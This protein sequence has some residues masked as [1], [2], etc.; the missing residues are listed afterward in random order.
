MKYC[1]TCVM[2]DTRPGIVFDEEGVCSPCRNYENRANVDW[3][4]RWQE[5]LEL[6]DTY[7]GCN[8]D[9]YDCLI[10][11]SGGKDSHYQTYVFKEVLG[12]NPLL[13]SVD[14]FSWTETG[15]LNWANLRTRF[16]V[17]NAASV[18]REGELGAAGDSR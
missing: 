10:A 1:K 14:N 13:V 3:D 7:R 6:A 11:A 17:D 2:P 16:G 18:Q 5:L 8:G 12:M 4:A 9:Y 15:R